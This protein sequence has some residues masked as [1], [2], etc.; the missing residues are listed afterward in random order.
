MVSPYGYISTKDKHCP[1]IATTIL[2]VLKLHQHHFSY[3]NEEAAAARLESTR[4]TSSP[5]QNEDKISCFY[6][7]SKTKKRYGIYLASALKQNLIQSLSNVGA[8]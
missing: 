7:S 3:W 1:V 6:P 8:S 2:L 4:K 5:I